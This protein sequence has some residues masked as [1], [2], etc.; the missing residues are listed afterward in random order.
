[1]SLLQ[2]S[3]TEV[4]DAALGEELTKGTS[5]VVW[6]TIIATVVVS[7]AVSAFV[8][9]EQKPPIATGEIVAVWAHPQHTETSGLDANGMPMPKEVADQVMVFT[10]VNLRNQTDHPLFLSNVLTNVTLDD[11]IHSSYAANKADYD[12]I[13]I[14]YP[15]IPVPHLK[16]ISPLDTTI[17]PGQTVEG[18][19]VSAFMMTK[20]QWDARKKLDYTFSFHYQPNLVLAPK[21]AITEQ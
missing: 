14:A 3:S 9:L 7:L 10:Q 16:P 21:V 12:R 5:H 20:Q 13:Y 17:D 8:I 2:Q 4:D 11:G 1:M 19:F 6:A 15:H 18:T